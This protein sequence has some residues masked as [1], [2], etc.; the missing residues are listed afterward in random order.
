MRSQEELYMF[1]EDDS[2]AEVC[3]EVVEGSI[4]SGETFRVGYGSFGGTL[5]GDASKC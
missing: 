4:G 1:T 5:E 3:I 2:T